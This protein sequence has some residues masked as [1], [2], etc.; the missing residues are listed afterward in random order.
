VAG[1]R[2]EFLEIAGAHYPVDGSIA[3]LLGGSMTALLAGQVD[4]IHNDDYVTILSHRGRSFVRQGNWKI[5]ADEQPFDEADFE[6]FDLAAD[7]G[8]TMDLSAK[9]PEKRE[10]MIDLWQTQR[11]TLGIVLPADL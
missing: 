5:V 3:S 9:F 1:L 11:K 2:P 6:L 7:P 4:S 8:E 10:E